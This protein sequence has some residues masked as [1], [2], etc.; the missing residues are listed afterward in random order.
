MGLAAGFGLQLWPILQNLQQLKRDYGD[1]WETFLASAAVR[2]FFAPTDDFTAEYTS[3]ICGVTTTTTPGQSIQH[4]AELMEKDRASTSWSQQSQRL[5][6]PHNVRGLGPYECLILGPRNTVIDAFRKPYWHSKDFTDQYSP[7]PYHKS[8]GVRADTA[9][10]LTELPPPTD[11][12]A[13]RHEASL[14]ET[15]KAVLKRRALAL[16]LLTWGASDRPAINLLRKIEYFVT[17]PLRLIAALFAAPFAVH[18][19]P[20]AA[21]L[22]L[23]A[24]F[25]FWELF[26]G[27]AKDPLVSLYQHKSEEFQFEGGKD[28]HGDILYSNYRAA[29]YVV[30]AELRAL[31]AGISGV[32]PP[33]ATGSPVERFIERMSALLDCEGDRSYRQM[34]VNT[35]VKYLGAEPTTLPPCVV[36]LPSAGGKSDKD[37]K[38]SGKRAPI[39]F[40]DGTNA[41]SEKL[42]PIPLVDGTDKGSGALA[43]IPFNDNLDKS[44]GALAPIP[45]NDTVANTQQ[46]PKTAPAKLGL[47]ERVWNRLRGND[48]QPVPASSKL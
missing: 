46:I 43:P 13:E 18:N 31:K 2:Q 3:Q 1:N 29:L 28:T 21:T 11:S 19:K 22:S 12:C 45:F 16:R 44:S 39:P 30:G 14:D 10:K 4:G 15:K 32:D 48:P 24:L 27:I 38:S 47:W 34:R 26:Y 7:D 40:S 17:L 20:L 8:E 9:S 36:P 35:E 41:S 42:A 23:L 37:E 6:L 5:I 25:G 33:D